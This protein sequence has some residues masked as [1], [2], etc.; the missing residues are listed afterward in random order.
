MCACLR[1]LTSATY[2]ASANRLYIM[3]KFTITS[4]GIFSSVN[5]S[6]ESCRKAAK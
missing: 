2:K 1:Y 3:K 4:I 5:V 6:C